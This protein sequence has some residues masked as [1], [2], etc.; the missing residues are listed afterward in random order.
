MKP[1]R[2]ILLSSLLILFACL[3]LGRFGFGMVLPNLEQSLTISTTLSGA[4]GTANFLGYFLG[5]FFVSY[6]Y[7]RFEASS[8]IAS[9]LLLQALSM[10]FMTLTNHYE[11]VALFYALSGFF[12]AISNVAV[13][14]YIAHVT[15]QEKRGKALGFIITGFGYA[16]IF[17]GFYVP[18]IE[19]WVQTNAWKTSWNSF[20]FLTLLVAL[21]AKL[22][23]RSKDQQQHQEEIPFDIKTTLQEKA[24]WKITWIYFV[25]GVTYVVYITYFVYAVIDKYAIDIHQG[26]NFWAIL[27]FMSLISSPLLGSL[28][29]KIGGYKTLIIVYSILSISHMILAFDSPYAILIFSAVLFGFS[30][31]SIPPLI[32]LLTSLHFGKHKT[33]QVFSMVTIIFAIGQAIAPVLAGYMYDLN[34]SFNTVFFI[35]MVLCMSAALSA[36]IFSKSKSLKTI[37]S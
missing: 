1:Y 20:A 32:T 21:V 37:T 11:I 5:I 36:F 2:T 23:L 6:L 30:A 18:W 4:I 8:L 25:F 17:S 22:G 19:T 28:A 10:G 13:M 27:G 24:F 16:I 34:G 26:G 29:D 14:V 33:A 9:T 12:S 3:G 35:C 7:K 31:W 15:P